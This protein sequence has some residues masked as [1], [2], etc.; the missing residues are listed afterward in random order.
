MELLKKL[1]MRLINY[2]IKVLFISE[3]SDKFYVGQTSILL[4]TRQGEHLI[5]YKDQYH[6]VVFY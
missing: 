2:R 3:D 6:N 1:M 5:K 4:E